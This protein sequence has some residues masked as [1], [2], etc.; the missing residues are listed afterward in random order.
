MSK[1]NLRNKESGMALLIALMALF[2]ISAIGLGMM[3]MSTGETSINANYKDTQ[4]AFFAMRG[5]LE[6]ARDRLRSNSPHPVPLPTDLA[7]NVALPGASNSIVYITNPSSGETVDPRRVTLSGQANPYYDD[8]LCHEN[9]NPATTCGSNL[10]NSMVQWP[11]TPSVAPYT[12]T[13]SPLNY[14]W[15]R[16][17]L[18]ANDTFTNALVNPNTGDHSQVCWNSGT[19]QEV[20]ATTLGYA[21]CP[22]AKAHGLNV[23]PVYI[24]TSLAITPQGSRRIGQYETAA[25][26]V[27]PPPGA[28]S[29]DGPAAA[30]PA[31]GIF[32]PVPNSN[33]Y[34]INGTDG[35]AP[36]GTPPATPNGCTIPNPPDT[37]PAI[38][39]SSSGVTSIMNPTTGIPSNRYGNYS[40]GTNTLSTNPTAVVTDETSSLTGMYADA[41]SLNNLVNMLANGADTTLNNCSMNGTGGSPC[42]PP[43]QGLG[44]PANPLITYVNGDLNWSGSTN[45]AGVLIVTG[46]LNIVGTPTF[47]GLVLV[48]GQGT[49]TVQGGGNG[50]FFGSLF[51]ANTNSRTSPFSQLSTL[52]QP[53]L[54]WNGGGGNGIY[55]NSCWADMINGMHFQVVA[56]REE[57]Y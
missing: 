27:T 33:P 3:Y 35:S 15:V 18:K 16:V 55:Y 26:S 12:N 36:S 4:L 41:A 48:I 24:I 52:G 49:M 53:S 21:D 25:E 45:G 10:P 17:T 37:A 50:T 29:L 13:A 34:H 46:N 56:S 30:P 47:D 57:M 8:E 38:G 11:A 22:T 39:T 9:L 23:G 20:T 31:Q 42:V 43:S 32:Q 19:N 6:E 44:T 7:G 40:S 2:L 51:V 54:Q 1:R 28:L 14:K 5:G